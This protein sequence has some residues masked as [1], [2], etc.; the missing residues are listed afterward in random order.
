MISVA[1]TIA[2]LYLPFLKLLLSWDFQCTSI[3]R[4]FFFFCY[5]YFKS[6]LV[7]RVRERKHHV[8]KRGQRMANLVKAD[9]K[10]LVTQISQVKSYLHSVKS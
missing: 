6:R 3:S 7:P 4:G 10:A 8:D 1:L 2:C 9:R 5:Y